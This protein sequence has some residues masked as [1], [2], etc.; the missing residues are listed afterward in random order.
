MLGQILIR[1]VSVN[2]KIENL[3]ERHHSAWKKNPT[4]PT[5]IIYTC[6]SQARQD[7]RLFF[8]IISR[9][10][11]NKS[12]LH[13]RSNMGFYFWKRRHRILYFERRRHTI[14]C[15]CWSKVN[16][17]QNRACSYLTLNRKWKTYWVNK[18]SH[19]NWVSSNKNIWWLGRCNFSRNS[20]IIYDDA[21]ELRYE[22]IRGIKC[23]LIFV[24]VI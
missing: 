14:S 12:W 15:S 9:S 8:V 11:Y 16:Q 3:D 1:N 23:K 17:E 7:R 18:K 13:T 5:K 2:K 10:N 20:W 19:I 24:R 21:D 4:N 22:E 6:L